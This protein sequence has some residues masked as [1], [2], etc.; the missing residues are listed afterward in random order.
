LID[1]TGKHPA[2]PHGVKDAT[3]KRKLIKKWWSDMPNANVG[4]AT[5]KDAGIVVL[6][7]DPRNGGLD[8]LK[9]L[10]ADLGEL[11]QTITSETGGGGEHRIFAYPDVPVRKDT[12]GKLL[13]A[14]VDILSDGSI[15]VA[16]PSGHSSGGRYKWADGKSFKELK[17]ALLPASWLAK[18]K[19]TTP[20]DEP[21]VTKGTI[22]EGA[23]N[24]TLTSLG[25]SLQRSG[26]SPEAISAALVAENKARCVPPLDAA[27]VETIVKSVGRYRAPPGGDRSDDAE[28][29]LNV[30]LSQHFKDGKHLIFGADGHFWYY[31]GKL[32][33]PVQDKWIEGQILKSIQGNPLR[34]SQQSASLMGQVRRLLEA[35]LAERT[36]PL[37]FLAEPPCVINCANGEIWIASDG[38]IELRSHRPESH[39]RYCLDVSYDPKAKCPEYGRALLGIFAKATNPEYMS[40][41]WNELVGYVIQPR[42]NLPLVAILLGRGDNGK[43][44]LTRT[45]VKLLGTAQVQAQRVEELEK[46]RF[47]MGS[48]LG[49][50]LFL[51][52]DVRAGARLPDGILKTI[53][54]AKEVTGENKYKPPFNFVVR[55]VPMLL[56]NNVPSLADVSHGMLR[57]LTVIPFDRIF[58][59]K[60]KDSD[61]FER[62]W[63]NE[64][65]GVLN[66]ALEGYA[67][68]LKRGRFK[69]PLAVTEA[70]TRWLEQANPIPAFLEARCIKTVDAECWMQE[71]YPA[72]K[73]WATQAG[74]NAGVKMHRFAG[75]K[76]HQ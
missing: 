71:L 52:D 30:V 15:M 54:E 24:T 14:G 37:G 61:L 74:V 10:E 49:K 20:V 35:K 26:A 39:L 45:I 65:P 51:D 64:L 6:D 40:R 50:L 68:L 13:G 21:S 60:D 56:C 48:L 57:R 19:A 72:Y 62:I 73:E 44:V 58:T 16:P 9:K 4:V 29:L 2:T 63:S 23:R 47:A 76:V 67:R 38:T 3:T 41:H 17:P 11:P 12:A 25:G 5:G 43:T 22:V 55:T 1:S 59:D 66:R 28:K 70:T 75:A 69:P 53:S 42:R 8:T 27:E 18:L 31:S 36:D 46:N 33:M 34:T 7:I 32:W